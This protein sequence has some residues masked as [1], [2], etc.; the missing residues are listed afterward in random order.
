MSQV[1]LVTYQGGALIV[2][3]NPADRLDLAV[4][5]AHST[6]RKVQRHYFPGGESYLDLADLGPGR[7][8]IQI[9]P[10]SLVKRIRGGSARYS[11]TLHRR[12]F[13]LLIIG[14]G[15]CGTTTLA[16][17]LDGLRF[18]DGE[19]ISARHESLAHLQ[20]QNIIAG[21]KE[22]FARVVS[23]QAHNVEAGAFY[24]LVPEALTADKIIHLVRDGRRVVQSGMLRG[25]YQNDSQ[26]NR[27]KPD[28][29]GTI[30]EKCCHLWVHAC[31]N[32]DRVAHEV[33]RL[34][35]LAGAEDFRFRVL[36]ELDIVADGRPFPHA[37]KGGASSGHEAWDRESRRSFAKI[38]GEM[39]DRHY[40]GW[41]N[42]W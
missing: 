24:A 31:E 4:R 42:S 28:F 29:P 38:C 23:G 20:L 40:P 7:C 12:P 3:N 41:A 10:Q 39:M 8:E 32:S 34:E 14:S 25:W 13:R 9:K 1:Q 18:G 35:D 19:A 37:N 36:R 26:W 5:V 2:R 16:R 6:R 17:Y 15:R 22:C 21:N 27:I 11:E 30:F 33:L